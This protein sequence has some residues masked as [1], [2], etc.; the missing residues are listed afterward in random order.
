MTELSS[1]LQSEVQHHRLLWRLNYTAAVILFL[2]ALGSSGLA[3]VFAATGTLGAFLPWLTAA[4]G[5]ILLANS[6]FKFNDKYAWHFEKSSK[7]KAIYQQVEYGNTA[8]KEV[9]DW[10][11][12]VD[13]EMRAK[14]PQFGEFAVL[15]GKNN[16]D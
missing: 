8:P 6:F 7:L 5:L 4:P 2:A 10:W 12:K 14:L 3:T 16:K 9:V 15:P 1:R 11:N 13:E